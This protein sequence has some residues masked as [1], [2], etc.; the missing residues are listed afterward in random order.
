M[1]RG[2]NFYEALFLVL[3]ICKATETRLFGHVPSLFVVFSPFLLA[4]VYDIIERWLKVKNIPNRIA[5]Y[6]WKLFVN[7]KANKARKT[8]VKEMDSYLKKSANPGQVYDK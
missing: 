6:F 8:A 3:L 7:R 2:I 1:K 4:A 5:F